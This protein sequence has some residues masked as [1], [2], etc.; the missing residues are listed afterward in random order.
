VSGHDVVTRMEGKHQGGRLARAW[1]RTR[2]TAVFVANS[3]GR[4]P[5][6]SLSKYKNIHQ[7]FNMREAPGTHCNGMLKTEQ[8]SAVVT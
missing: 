6:M 7:I 3:T 8:V 2:V 4:L 1:A 5:L